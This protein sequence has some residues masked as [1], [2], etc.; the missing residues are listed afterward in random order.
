VILGHFVGLS[1]SV[2][3]YFSSCIVPGEI[4]VLLRPPSAGRGE[5]LG[6]FEEQVFGWNLGGTGSFPGRVLPAGYNSL[7]ATDW[8]IGPCSAEKV[9]RN[10]V[11]A[12]R[13]PCGI[14]SVFGTETASRFEAGNFRPDESS[15]V[16]IGFSGKVGSNR[17]Y[18]ERF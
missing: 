1:R 18:L 17:V 10:K 9:F 7:N 16:L 11:V 13:G 15:E 5:I 6:L 4:P 3:R 2:S 12:P 8:W 14:E